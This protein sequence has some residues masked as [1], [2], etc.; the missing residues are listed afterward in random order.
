MSRALQSRPAVTMVGI[1]SCIQH[2]HV[3]DE[4]TFVYWYDK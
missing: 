2:A 1:I 3:Y 4:F